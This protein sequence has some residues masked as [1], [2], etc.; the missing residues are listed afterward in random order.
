MQGDVALPGDGSPA[1]SGRAGWEQHRTSTVATLLPT[2]AGWLVDGLSVCMRNRVQSA[3]LPLKHVGTTQPA[4]L[5]Y[6]CAALCTLHAVHCML[7]TALCS[8]QKDKPTCLLL[9]AAPASCESCTAASSGRSTPTATCCRM[10][11]RVGSTNAPLA[12][13]VRRRR[14]TVRGG[15]SRAASQGE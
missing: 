12:A 15:G 11:A 5:A 13:G 2:C 7:L 9:A 14:A 8:R 4:R 10:S 3:A 6:P 1:A